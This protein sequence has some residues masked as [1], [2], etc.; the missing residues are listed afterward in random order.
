MTNCRRRSAHLTA[1]MNS[2]YLNRTRTRPATYSLNSALVVSQSS[3]RVA[4]LG[5]DQHARPTTGKIPRASTQHFPVHAPSSPRWEGLS[6]SNLNK[7]RHSHPGAS[8]TVSQDRH[9]KTGQSGSTWIIWVTLGRDSTT[10]MGEDSP[11]LQHK[12]PTSL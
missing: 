2:P 6:M 8:L 10:Q 3:S 9:I 4:I 7:P 5:L 12:Q 1:R 11:M